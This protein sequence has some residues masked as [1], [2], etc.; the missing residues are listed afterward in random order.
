MITNTTK[1]KV[2]LQYFEHGSWF[3]STNSHQQLFE[4]KMLVEWLQ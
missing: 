4:L 3:K 2:V 1:K